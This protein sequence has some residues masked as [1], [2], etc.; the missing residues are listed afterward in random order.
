MVDE[1]LNHTWRLHILQILSTK[2]NGHLQKHHKNRIKYEAVGELLIVHILIRL[3]GVPQSKVI[4]KCC[5]C[6]VVTQFAKHKRVLFKKME[7]TTY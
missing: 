3:K 6:L 1:A 5:V 2:D 4:L 7:Y